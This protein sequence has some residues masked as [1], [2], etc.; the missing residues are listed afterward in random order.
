MKIAIRPSA[1]V[2]CN[3]D[4]DVLENPAI[5]IE[6]GRISYIGPAHYAPPFEADETV[7]GEHLVAMPG[8]VNTHTHAAMTLVRGY[9]DDMALEPWLSQKIWP[10]EANLEAQHVYFGTLL[11]ILE[12]VRGGTTTFADMYFFGD[13]GARAMLESGIRACPGA[14]LLGFLPGADEKIASG[15]AWAKNWNGE[16]N[17]RIVPTMAPHSLYT[18]D[19]NQWR[20]MIAGARDL[21]ILMHTHAGE[22][23][24]EVADVRA[25]WGQ[26]PIQTLQKIGALDGPLM[27]A[28]CVHTDETDREIMA[29]HDLRVAHNPQ[30]NLKLA[31]GIAPILDYQKRGLKIGLGPDGTASN[32][33]LDMWEELRL[34][35]TLHKATSGEPTAISAREALE[36]ATIGGARCLNLDAEIGSLEIGKKAD[37]VLVDFDKPHLYPRHNV[38]SHLV[39][40]AHSSDVCATMVDGKW[41]FKN[42][43]FET[44]DAAKICA[45]CESFARDLVRKAQP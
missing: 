9:A 6:N 19:E 23:P 28:H 37:L 36:M 4:F 8:L 25:K 14:V 34:A 5:H 31:S 15:I 40:A 12:M 17:G 45:T 7:A 30:S 42:G 39:Y 11:A 16:G 32:N 24:K 21:G 26:S 43:E 2:T 38:V 44:L 20:K 1:A 35:A 18:C 41:L 22:T 10:Y 33:N 27:A 13:D 3:S 29:A